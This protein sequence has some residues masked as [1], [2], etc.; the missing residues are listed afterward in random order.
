[1]Q[2]NLKL[3]IKEAEREILLAMSKEVRDILN[4]WVMKIR[5]V[6]KVTISKSL[7]DSPTVSS[8]IDGELYGDIGVLDIQN[9]VEKIV[10]VLS[11][12]YSI[13]GPF[14][15]IVG[16]Q[17]EGYV[18]LNYIESDYTD[19]LSMD[20]ASYLTPEH[21][22]LLSWLQWLLLEGDGNIIVGWKLSEN[23]LNSFSRTGTNK[24]MRKS[25]TGVFKIR[26]GYGG[27]IDDN[28]IT[29]SI[30]SIEAGLLKLMEGAI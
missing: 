15:A 12:P 27:T 10:G 28:F 17:I 2:A 30:D 16:K 1:M 25:K 20:E 22:Y 11:E 29:R 3:D 6:L 18:A 4:K 5:P 19:I 24:T 8:L 7:M 26:P 13:D 9:K 21:Q 14:V 23:S